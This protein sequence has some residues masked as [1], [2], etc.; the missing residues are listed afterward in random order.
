V[1]FWDLTS[2]A[3]PKIIVEQVAPHSFILQEGFRY[4]APFRDEPYVA[5]ACEETDLASVPWPLWWLIASYGR[6]TKAALIHDALIEPSDRIREVDRVPRREADRMFFY[7]LR[8]S[9]F[10]IPREKRRTSWLRR[11]VM[12][13]AVAILGTMR[14][15]APL[16]LVLFLAHLVAFV[17]L[18][19]CFVLGRWVDSVWPLSFLDFSLPVVDLKPLEGGRGLLIL[20]VAGFLWAFNRRVD[21]KLGFG[22]WPAAIFAVVVALPFTLLLAVP[23]GIFAIGDFV[24]NLGL[25]V[26]RREWQGGPIVTPTRTPGEL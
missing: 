15:E 5:P 2:T 11:W 12:Y 6:H 16:W 26:K 24:Y 4:E 20:G 7:A 21:T 18:L 23:A 1:P 9:G 13:A 22:L 10:G 19:T 8:E 3:E 17:G 14:K 25:S